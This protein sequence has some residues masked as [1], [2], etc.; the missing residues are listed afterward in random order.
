MWKIWDGRNSTVFDSTRFEPR[1]ILA[2]VK[3]FFSEID[4][5]FSTL[6]NSRNTWSD[7]VITRNIG[8]STRPAPLPR[9]VE[10]HWWPP[11]NHWIKVNTDGSALGAPGAIAASG[12]FRDKWSVVRGCFHIKGGVGFAFEAELLAVITAINLAHDR[13]WLHL[14]IEADSMYVVHL[15]Q[16]KSLDVPWRFMAL[17]KGVIGRLQDFNLM[18]SHIYREGNRPAD[19]MANG[20]RN[21][22]WRPFAISEIEHAVATDMYTHSHVRVV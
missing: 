12:V 1:A 18:V 20:D 13:N 11:V 19:I 16:S 17:W 15:L 9:M 6:G 5:N 2:F 3:S 21:E 14:W 8:V 7:Y 4:G 22:G 10:V